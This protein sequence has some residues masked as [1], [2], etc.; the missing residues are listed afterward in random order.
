M[1]NPRP[2]TTVM[3]VPYEVDENEPDVEVS[4][5]FTPGDKGDA[6]C[7]PTGDEVEVEDVMHVVKRGKRGGWVRT[8]ETRSFDALPEDVQESFQEDILQE[9][10]ESAAEAAAMAKAC[11]HCRGRNCDEC[12]L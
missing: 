12:P 6:W 11:R 2:S 7:P 8:G 10:A 4:Y 9:A 5:Y 3:T 1:K